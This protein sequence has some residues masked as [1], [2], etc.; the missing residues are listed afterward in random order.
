MAADIY[1]HARASINAKQIKSTLQLAVHIAA[2]CTAYPAKSGPVDN[3]GL[4][5]KTIR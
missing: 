2:A 3:T 1:S 4:T 5:L